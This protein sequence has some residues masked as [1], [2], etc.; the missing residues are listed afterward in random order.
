MQKCCTFT[1]V[2]VD[3][4]GPT[5]CEK[6]S[7]LVTAK[8]GLLKKTSTFDMTKMDENILGVTG[9]A[10]G[11]LAALLAVMNNVPT[12]ATTETVTDTVITAI[13]FH[14]HSH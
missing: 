11:S 7:V 5:S 10:V 12:T 9:I 3:G 14:Y 8:T 1:T 2:L 13:L 6:S 4:D